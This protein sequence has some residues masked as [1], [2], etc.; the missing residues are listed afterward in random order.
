MSLIITR[1]CSNYR[2]CIDEHVQTHRKNTEKKNE[3]LNIFNVST[4]SG[5]SRIRQAHRRIPALMSVVFETRN[6]DIANNS[7]VSGCNHANA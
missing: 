2:A 5:Q 7:N 3:Q 6:A 1:I 4:S